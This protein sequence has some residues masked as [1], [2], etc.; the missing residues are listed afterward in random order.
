MKRKIRKLY[1]D[2]TDLIPLWTGTAFFLDGLYV[3]IVIPGRDLKNESM[4]E[5]SA[6]FKV[7]L[8]TKH[9]SKRLWIIFAQIFNETN[10]NVVWE[11][12]LLVS[13]LFF[14]VPISVY[15]CPHKC[16]YLSTAD[17]HSSPISSFS[18][19]EPKIVSPI[20]KHNMTKP[21]ILCKY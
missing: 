2:D 9:L 17:N 16:K 13:S 7:F 5:V 12:I 10:E 20:A 8:F 21:I 14:L 19:S 4:N 11:K 15:S 1:L 18:N 3:V 6:F